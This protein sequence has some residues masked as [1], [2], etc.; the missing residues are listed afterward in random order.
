MF[1]SSLHAFLIRSSSPVSAITIW[2][3][4]AKVEALKAQKII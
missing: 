1:F 4:D 3:D 2:D